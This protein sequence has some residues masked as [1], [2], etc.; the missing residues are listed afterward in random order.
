MKLKGL[1]KLVLAGTALAATAA[2]LTTATYA[3]YVVNDHVEATGMTGKT[4][5]SSVAGSLLISRVDT[6]NNNVPEGYTTEIALTASTVELNPM[7]KATDNKYE[8]ATGT[9]YDATAKYYTRSGTEGNYTYSPV[10]TPAEAQLSTYFLKTRGVGDWVDK[11]GKEIDGTLITYSFWLKASS[12]M[13]DIKVTTTFENTTTEAKKQTFYKGVGLPS[14]K[15]NGD[16]YAVDV[17]NALRM[18]VVQQAYDVT[19][20]KAIEITDTEVTNENFASLKTAGKLVKG[21]AGSYTLV[22]ADAADEFAAGTYHELK[23]GTGTTNAIAKNT[24]DTYNVTKE[25]SAL[26]HHTAQQDDYVDNAIFDAAGGDA[27][28]YYAAVM[29]TGKAGYGTEG[30]GGAAVGSG[31]TEGQSPTLSDDAWSTITLAKDVDYLITINIWL[32]GTDSDCW[33]S[34]VGQDFK[35]SLD[36][37]ATNA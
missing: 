4:S 29:G 17:V 9:T 3:W 23:E 35:L 24:S 26:A 34:C 16:T 8:S 28:K 11:T 32:E 21:T 19:Y 13:S 37:K 12:N 2:T 25:A 5:G 6:T 22:A 1:T 18:E 10:E 36:F 7:T 33:D 27:N 31:K 15:V 30:F 20:T 14:T